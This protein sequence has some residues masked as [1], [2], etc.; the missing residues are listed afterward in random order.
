MKNLIIW[1]KR[2]EEC[3][4]LSARVRALEAPLETPRLNACTLDVKKS[5]YL[6]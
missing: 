6:G 4:I 5:S 1:V 3:L 2:M